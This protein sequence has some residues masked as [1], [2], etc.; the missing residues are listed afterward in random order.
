MKNFTLSVFALAA[1]LLVSQAHAAKI[2]EDALTLGKPGSSANKTFNLGTGQLRFNVG[3]SQ[4]EFSN[5]ATNYKAIGSGAGGAG[6]I[7]LLST[8]PDAESGTTD[9]TASGGTLAA[10][11]SSPLNG[12]KSFLFTPSA[13][14]QT[15][16]TGQK[17]VLDG[18]TGGACVGK[19]FYKTT[20]ATNRYILN[21]IDGSS[22][23]L[24]TVTLAPTLG[25][26]AVDAYVPF[27][28]PTS[29][30]VALQV[31][32]AAS[33]PGAAIKWDDEHLGSDTRVASISQ[34]TW[35]GSAFH[36]A[37]ASCSWTTASTSPVSMGTDAD[38]PTPTVAG[39]VTA[40]AT[41]LAGFTLQGPGR[42]EVKVQGARFSTTSA[43][44]GSFSWY[45]SDGTISSNA[46]IATILTAADHTSTIPSNAVFQLDV[47]D[48]NAH[49]FSIYTDSTD[50]AA[51]L[52]LVNTQTGLTN[53]GLSFNVFRYPTAGETAVKADSAAV[54]WSG[55]HDNTCSFGRTSTSLGDPTADASCGFTERKNRNFGT[56]TSY[57]S[58]LPGIVFAPAKI[59]R[60]FVCA[61]VMANQSS[62]GDGD[63]QLDDLTTVIARQS[64]R[65]A[66][67]STYRTIPLCG[68]WDATSTASATLR[69]QSA[70]SAGTIT[71][72]GGGGT[73]PGNAIEWMIFQLDAAQSA[74][75]FPGMVSS[76]S[77]GQERIER[78]TALI[79]GSCSITSQSGSWL[80]SVGSCGTGDVTF[81]IATGMFS[82][83]PTCTVT[84]DNTL[85][86]AFC[87]TPARSSTSLRVACYTS[88]TGAVVGVNAS[89]ICVG[90]K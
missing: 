81:T 88:T 86:S 69:I 61:N 16:T 53:A 44:D 50:G 31:K 65:D 63:L 49:T 59:G 71:L 52:A 22:N 29:G 77:S 74:P 18:L 67:T 13:G 5:D 38:C 27:Q 55:Y 3:S 73:T 36:P 79:S 34:A 75:V 28:C 30:T 70:T 58:K 39:S 89:I 60:Y 64:F 48:S 4:L 23:V 66:S 17:T 15:V 46:S 2:T 45:L 84:A 72:A 6:G 68:I 33:T 12:V 56:V 85:G 32:A 10:S 76:N 9:H 14:A 25:S 47:T 8:N 62:T 26:N 54:S 90:P 78:A 42:F 82:A 80:S 37:T 1:S 35:Y 51:T 24:G 7:N 19:I 43:S 87:A 83:A 20:E 40:P 57:G 41:K 21:A 11:S